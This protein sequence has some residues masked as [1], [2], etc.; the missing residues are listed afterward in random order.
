MKEPVCQLRGVG[1]N[2]SS[3]C[4]TWDPWRPGVGHAPPCK[5]P[6]QEASRPSRDTR[7]WHFTHSGWTLHQ[8]LPLGPDFSDCPPSS[9]PA[10]LHSYVLIS[11]LLLVYKHYPQYILNFWL[12][13]TVC[14]SKATA[15]T[16]AQNSQRASAKV[17]LEFTRSRISVS[18]CFGL[19]YHSDK[20]SA[21]AL[22]VWTPYSIRQISCI[23]HVD[24]Y[25]KMNNTRNTDAWTSL[26]L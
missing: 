7:V 1:L 24:D 18:K 9:C 8:E 11:G 23:L 19:A 20:V 2:E 16:R 12:H 26:V 14:F 6:R 13:P 25:V 21:T 4:S 5:A 3:S 10:S 15:N 22:W 17:C